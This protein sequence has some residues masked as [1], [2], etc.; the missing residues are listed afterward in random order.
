LGLN[1]DVEDGAGAGT[2]A[3]ELNRTAEVGV[4]ELSNYAVFKMKQT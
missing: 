1:G 2:S 3:A 4:K